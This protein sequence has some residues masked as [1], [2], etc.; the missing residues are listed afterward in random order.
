MGLPGRAHQGDRLRRQPRPDDVPTSDPAAFA[1]CGPRHAE[2]VGVSGPDVA[3]DLARTSSDLRTRR[4]AGGPTA[5][6]RAGRTGRS[7]RRA[8]R[9]RPRRPAGRWAVSTDS[10]AARRKQDVLGVRLLAG[11]PVGQPLPLGALPGGRGVGVVAAVGVR[12]GGL[13]RQ[14]QRRAQPGPVELDQLVER[15]RGLGGRQRVEDAALSASPPAAPPDRDR[16]P[17]LIRAARRSARPGR[18]RPAAG[19]GPPAVS[20]SATAACRRARRRR[21]RPVGCRPRAGRPRRATPAASARSEVEASSSASTFGP[22]AAQRHVAER[23]RRQ[24]ARGAARARCSRPRSSPASRSC[25]TR[26][27]TAHCSRLSSSTGS[28]SAGSSS[29]RVSATPSRCRRN[30][31]AGCVSSRRRSARSTSAAGS[32]GSGPPKIGAGSTRGPAAARAPAYDS[33]SKL[34]GRPAERRREVARVERLQRVVGGDDVAHPTGQ[35][36]QP[37]GPARRA[38]RRAARPAARARRC[39]RRRR[40][41]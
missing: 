15:R 13:D 26:S 32:D 35:P 25:S 41:R 10:G 27:P 12:G 28:A 14:R 29:P 33:G 9:R 16:P 40:C 19:A 5:A 34:N 37:S 7:R 2:S 21:C 24:R 39:V 8:S 18:S 17:R 3:N 20:R 6:G 31:R 4:R 36:R 23:P 11:E 30:P 1:T 22:I 38:A